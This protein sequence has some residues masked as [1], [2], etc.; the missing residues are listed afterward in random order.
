MSGSRESQHVS[1]H[2]ARAH[3]HT[4]TQKHTLDVEAVDC[5]IEVHVACGCDGDDLGVVREGFERDGIVQLSCREKRD[6]RRHVKWCTSHC[7]VSWRGWASS[8][9]L[10]E[11]CTSSLCLRESSR[12]RRVF[13]PRV[14]K[15]AHLLCMLVCVPFPLRLPIWTAGRERNE[16]ERPRAMFALRNVSRDYLLGL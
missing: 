12:R 2:H 5:V 13:A 9:C 7:I 6:T 14:E 1:G 15:T 11:R 3:K 4:H 16:R 10:I 8:Q